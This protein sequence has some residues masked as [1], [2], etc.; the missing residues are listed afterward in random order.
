[1]KRN[2]FNN[3]IGIALF[4]ALPALMISSC[5]NDVVAPTL[6]TAV[7]TPGIVT[8]FA[9]SG[10]YGS[11]NGTGAAA[12]FTY[13]TGIN[14]DAAGNLFVADQG[15]NQIRKITS[16]GVV[17]TVSGTLA[18]GSSN[19]SAI[20]A[21]ASYSSPSSV[22]VDITNNI[23]IADFANNQIRK[24]ATT[25]AVTTFAGTTSSG[26]VNAT[27]TL[28]KFNGPASVAVDAAGNVYVADFNNHAIRKVTAAGVVTTLAGGA[29]AGNVDGTGTA[30]KFNGPRSVAVDLTGNVYVADAN[31]N[32]IRKVSAAGVVTTLAGS[33]AIGNVDGNGAAATFFH[34]AGVAV[35]ANG[36]VYVAD[37]DNNL[38]RKITP[39]GAVTSVAGSGYLALI[40]PFNAPASVAVDAAGTNIYVASSLGN[41]IHKVK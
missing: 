3:I 9:G 31:N 28:A 6:P 11:G 36:N 17:S 32:K 40:T 29:G 20:G 16:A 18:P 27:G 14:F 12:S 26:N 35:D 41:T 10:S 24:I 4:T 7:T 30:A 34:P 13:P 2:R 8:I 25:G 39:A 19:A 33:G 37:T 1:M 21:V 23:Y 15:N 38:V 22:A 5:K